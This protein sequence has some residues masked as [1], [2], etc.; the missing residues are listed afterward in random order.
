VEIGF[1]TAV[2]E[3]DFAYGDVTGSYHFAPYTRNDDVRWIDDVFGPLS[4]V[5]CD[6]KEPTQVTSRGQITGYD[7]CS[8]L[9]VATM[10]D[11]KW[12]V[13]QLSLRGHFV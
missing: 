12:R 11:R 7:L 10:A 2:S 4:P 8:L 9:G 1:F 3:P 13:Q 6:E 5:A